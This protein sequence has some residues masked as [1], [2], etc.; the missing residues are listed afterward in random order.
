MAVLCLRI[1]RQELCR[2]GILYN[3]N[4]GLAQD[5]ESNTIACDVPVKPTA[6][7]VT[8]R[9][10]N[11]RPSRRHSALRSLLRCSPPP[12]SFMSD[13][14]N[15]ARLSIQASPTPTIQPCRSLPQPAPEP[16]FL[17]VNTSISSRRDLPHLYTEDWTLIHT[18][19][20]A[21]PSL[22]PTSEPGSWVLIDDS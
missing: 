20:N 12:L 17:N 10:G 15:I 14:A 13:D 18:P 11:L 19:Q 21:D 3:V 4:G 6:P 22:T 9:Y 7:K 2:L 1:L 16:R 8:Y 5:Y